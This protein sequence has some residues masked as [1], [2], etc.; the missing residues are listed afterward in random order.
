MARHR[1][2][3]APLVEGEPR[4]DETAGFRRRL[5]HHDAAREAGNQPVAQRE[6]PRHRVKPHRLF[7]QQYALAADICGERCVFRRVDHIDTARHHRNRAGV[8]CGQ[9]RRRVDPA[10]KAGDDGDPR[11]AEIA[12]QLARDAGAKCRGR[13]RADQRHHRAV[14]NGRV[15]LDPKHRRGIGKVGERLWI[16]GLAP[17][18]QPRPGGFSRLAFRV[19]DMFRADGVIA[20]PGR[21]GNP[22]QRLQ[23]GLC[24]PVFREQAPEGD[25]TDPAG[26]NETEPRQSVVF[27]GGWGEGGGVRKQTF[28]PSCL[29]LIRRDRMQPQG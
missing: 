22:R 2:H 8:K 1:Q 17:A 26:A 29:R 24:R 13:A 4:G 20:D 28:C 27:R 6:M 5:D 9:M 12:R 15:A 25:D 23:R 19:N 21:A 14:E 16:G 18:D 7:G 3:L 11:R 10:R